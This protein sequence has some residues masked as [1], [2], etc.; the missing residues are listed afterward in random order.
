MLIVWKNRGKKLSG[1]DR[2]TTA[3]EFAFVFPVFLTFI[4]GTF[5]LAGIMFGTALLEGGLREAA[6]YGI[7]GYSSG[8]GVSR[9]QQ[10]LDVL[11][12]HGAGYVK[13]TADELKTLVY[14]NFDTIGDPEPFVDANGN[15][16]YDA[17]ESFTDLNCNGSW[18]VDAGLNGAGS[19]GEVVLYTVEHEMQL[20]TGY[21]ASLIGEDG[22]YTLAAS[23]AVR[24]EPYG[25]GSSC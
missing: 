25:G 12:A 22:K 14:K 5:D 6:R 2:G 18:D 10:I 4:L 8:G 3:L 11:N 15:S 13:I 21:M 16:N 19:G 24:N 1:C 7:T 17:G 23:V 9:E 20:I